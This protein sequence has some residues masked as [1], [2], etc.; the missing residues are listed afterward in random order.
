LINE[1]ETMDN[2]KAAIVFSLLRDFKSIRQAQLK[3]R[4]FG[5]F[6]REFE[7]LRLALGLQNW[8]KSRA[9]MLNYARQ[10]AQ[11]AA[12]GATD[13]AAQGAVDGAAQA[14]AD[15]AAQGAADGA[16]QGA[17]DGNITFTVSSPFSPC[18]PW[19]WGDERMYSGISA[20]IMDDDAMDDDAMDNGAMDNGAMDN[21]A[22]DDSVMDDSAMGDGA[23]DSNN[24]YVLHEGVFDNSG[25]GSFDNSGEG[26][27]DNSGWGVLDNSQSEENDANHALFLEVCYAQV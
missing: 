3:A 18:S 1:R 13:G 24:E 14:A 6:K 16:A 4:K 9:K 25:E 7:Q 17:V 23:M 11:A 10:A 20:N 15:G 19:I 27:F 5:I 22:M 12:D 21:G 8:N 26:V 2:D